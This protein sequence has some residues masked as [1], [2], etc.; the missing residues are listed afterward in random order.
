[1]NKHYEHML[2]LAL[3]GLMLCIIPAHGE[4]Y[5]FIW[6]VSA[7]WICGMAFTVWLSS[8]WYR[9]F[10][11]LALVRTATIWPPDAD[12]YLCLLTIAV[13]LAAAEGFKRIDS[14]K[15]MNWIC[16]AGVVLFGWTLAQIYGFVPAY[17]AGR[18]IG[19]LNPDAGGVFFAL[20]LI[21]FFRMNVY[22]LIWIPFVGIIIS[23]STTAAASALAGIVVMLILNSKV[24]AKQ[25]IAALAV[26]AVVGGFWI[27]KIDPIRDTLNCTRWVAWKHAVWSFQSESMGRGLGSWKIVFPLLASGDKRLGTVTNEK[28]VITFENC[29]L[30][31]H[32]DYLQTGFELG[33]QE[34]AVVIGFLIYAAVLAVMGKAGA[35]PAAGVAAL[36]VASLGWSVFRNPLLALIGAAWLGMWERS[37]K[38]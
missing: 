4:E 33:L 5:L 13:F 34:L 12:G 38:K 17:F 24:S 27:W 1:M 10:F 28:G 29:F 8:W 3:P 31:A 19:P 30:N 18:S 23:A 25:L 16:L 36:A 37:L 6:Q 2:L 32:N 7:L 22:R 15:T 26:I 11:F 35:Y 21:A 9:A 20:C 14:D